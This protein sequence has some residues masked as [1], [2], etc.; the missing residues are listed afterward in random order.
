M[1]LSWFFGKINHSLF[2]TNKLPIELQEKIILER[3]NIIEKER[4]LLIDSLTIEELY[5]ELDKKLHIYMPMEIQNSQ[6]LTFKGPFNIIVMKC[7]SIHDTVD[8]VHLSVNIERNN[9]E[10]NDNTSGFIDYWDNASECTQYILAAQCYD[11][12]NNAQNNTM[13]FRGEEDD[14][15]R[16]SSYCFDYLVSAFGGNHDMFNMS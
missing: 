7:Y 2:R 5:F 11:N 9:H 14:F 13:I 16:Y 8:A 6:S 15:V 3:D 10:N 12:I 4:R 1:N